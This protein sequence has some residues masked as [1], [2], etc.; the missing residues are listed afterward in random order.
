M[1]ITSR[2]V[3]TRQS[4]RVGLLLALTLLLGAC[5]MN[6]ERRDAVG[7]FSRATARFGAMA[8]NE[9]IEARRA[10][11]DLNTYVVALD[12]AKLPRRQEL[13]GPFTPAAVEGRVRAAEALR[14]YGEL[15]AAIV[16]DESDVKV[17][18]AAQRFT[19]SIKQ[20]DRATVKLSDDE[21]TAIGKA[22]AAIGGIAI[23][24]KR[25]A[26]LKEIVPKAH[27]QVETL[28]KLFAGEFDPERGPIARRIDATAQLALQA[29][30]K[31][32][33]NR[34]APVADR[35]VA[36]EAMRD[37]LAVVRR[38][39]AM[40]PALAKAADSLVAAHERLVKALAADS[41]SFADVKAFADEM[42]RLT[43]TA[44]AHAIR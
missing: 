30:D 16:H 39:N 28:G 23:D 21:L 11:V 9:I 37:S 3:G 2:L 8:S 43:A 12:P 15:L 5:G 33:D 42:G 19:G 32:L 26:A 38:N 18:H 24:E 13:E 35:Y 14:R 20:L 44:K 1:V 41:F 27:P 17:A 36:A 10:V 25:T 34:A 6:T 22:T 4:V 40:M 31:T 7:E 29:A